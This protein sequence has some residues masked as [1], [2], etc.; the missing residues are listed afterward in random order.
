MKDLFFGGRSNSALYTVAILR[1]SI[2]YFS[3]LHVP[4]R[5]RP[6]VI[7]PA[8]AICLRITYAKPEKDG[9]GSHGELGGKME[10]DC[11][12]EYGLCKV[13]RHGMNSSS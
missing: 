4:D 10:D 3:S 12:M 9:K 5:S 7:Y 11:S 6:S 8:P 1:W 13:T 2:K